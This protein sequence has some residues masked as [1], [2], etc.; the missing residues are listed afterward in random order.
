MSPDLPKSAF[1]P[2]GKCHVV[3]TFFLIFLGSLERPIVPL[4]IGLGP[5]TLRQL[6]TEILLWLE[7]LSR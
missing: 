3:L 4:E 5:F 7:G 2:H 6:Y 1:P